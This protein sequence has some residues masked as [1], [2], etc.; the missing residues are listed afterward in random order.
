M[1][2]R[3]LGGSR[4]TTPACLGL[5]LRGWTVVQSIGSCLRITDDSATKGTILLP[6][7][8]KSQK[9]Y[10]PDDPSSK[11]SEEGIVQ[12]PLQ[13]SVFTLITIAI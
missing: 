11:V 5:S 3:P 4:G 12:K 10:R 8:I 2:S 13:C 7:R 6:L 9:V 1:C